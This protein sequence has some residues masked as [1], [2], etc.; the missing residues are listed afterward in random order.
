MA[1]FDGLYI[2]EFQFQDLLNMVRQVVFVGHMTQLI[3]LGKGKILFFGD[4]QHAFAFSIIEKLAFL[5]EELEGVPL[6]GVMAGG[7][8]DSSSGLLTGDG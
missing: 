8:D 1:F 3:H 4:C 6:L 7:E 2:H 5:V